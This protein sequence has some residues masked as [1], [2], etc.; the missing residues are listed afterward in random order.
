MGDEEGEGMD[1]LNQ[2][3]AIAQQRQGMA[4]GGAAPSGQP[5][6]GSAS[7]P[8]G[9]LTPQGAAP[10]TAG[11]TPGFREAVDQVFATLYSGNPADLQYFGMKM[12]E[13]Q[14]LVQEHGAGTAPMQTGAGAPQ[15]AMG[16]TPR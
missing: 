1:A 14:R 9:G 3:M 15:P 6:M 11:E 4:T 16:G 2:Q 12:G 5:P 8:G 13:M 10:Q 7:S